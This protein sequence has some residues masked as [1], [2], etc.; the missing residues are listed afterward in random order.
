[1]KIN[2]KLA[3]PPL[4]GLILISL[5]IQLYWIPLQ[6]ENAKTEYKKHTYELLTL[7]ESSIAKSLLQRDLGALYVHLEYLEETYK[8]R[9]QNIALYNY[10]NKR[11]YPIVKPSLNDKQSKQLIHIVHELSS[12]EKYL[13]RIELDVNWSD[14]RQTVISDINK[15]RNMVIGLVLLSQLIA[16]LSQ[17]KII[18][19][20][21][22]KLSL[23][24]QKVVEG[25]FR[26]A[27][28]SLTEDEI[29]DL[30]KA[31]KTMVEELAFRKNALDEH[32]IISAVDRSGRITY[33]NTKF[34]QISGYSE[35]ELLGK[36]HRVIKS[37]VH[38]PEFY[39]S[40]WSTITQGKVW[41]GEICNLTKNGEHYWVS[42]TIVPFLNEHGVPQRYISLRTDITEQKSAE[43]RL[44]HMANHDALTGLA[45]RRLCREKLSTAIAMAHRHK[46]CAAVL[47]IDLDG[48]KTINDS[49]GHDAGDAVL[50]NVGKRLCATVREMDTVARIGGDEFMVVLSDISDPDDIKLIAQKLINNLK[51]PFHFNEQPL[52]IGA[53]IGIAL[54]PDHAQDAERLI[55][56]A[57]EAMY[58]VKSNGK[59]NYAFAEKDSPPHTEHPH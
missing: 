22:K 59:N 34:L 35:E 25:D 7:G 56:R 15:V 52:Q 53:S 27:L 58:T 8:S 16:L 33:V 21:L 40:M 32:A 9:W 2:L 37:K 11:Y 30:S 14:K 23:A 4:I 41:Q 3:I 13:G 19:R 45:T 29:G 12:G 48:F 47:F 50:M 36:T 43:E 51:A 38:S 6:L 18:Y 39:K 54:Y 57:D 31:F 1:M 55:N 20:P 17:Y 28:P 10:N 42:S 5:I 24:T 46:K 26:P 49:Y 44:R